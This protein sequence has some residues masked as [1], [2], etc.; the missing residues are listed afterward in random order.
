[1]GN[2]DNIKEILSGKG[3]KST[4]QRLVIFEA[5][6]NLHNH[7]TAEDIFNFIKDKYPSISLS[8]VYNTLDLFVE[9]EIINTVKSDHGTIR[10]DSKTDKHHHL[11]CNE[12]NKIA[13]YYNNDLDKLLTEFFEKNQIQNFDIKEIKLQIKGNFLG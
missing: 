3:M 1:M 4:T 12:S 6:E 13:D 9:N 2:F 5:L 8:T 7:P 11:Y 10:Y